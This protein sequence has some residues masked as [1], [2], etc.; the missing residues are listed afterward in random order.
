MKD[1]FLLTL[2]ITISSLV[3]MLERELSDDEVIEYCLSCDE[4]RRFGVGKYGNRVVRIS[5]T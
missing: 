1:V 2:P 5:D 4:S 3:I